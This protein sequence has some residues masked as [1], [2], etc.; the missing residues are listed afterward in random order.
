[1]G[2]LGLVRVGLLRVRWLRLLRCLCRDGR[3]PCGAGP[4]GADGHGALG[5]ART[6]GG[7]F[8]PSG[9]AALADR[10]DGDGAVGGRLAT[11]R[12]G[13]RA[14][15]RTASAPRLAL[16]LALAPASGARETDRDRALGGA[17]R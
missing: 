9:G 10:A 6:A 17:G 4:Q 11:A 15:V 16:R 3:R 1:M 8:A 2:C 12:H 14:L 5:L 7:L 13:R